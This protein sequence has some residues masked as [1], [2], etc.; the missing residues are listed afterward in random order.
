LQPVEQARRLQRICFSAAAAIVLVAVPMG[1]GSEDSG[2]PPADV[3]GPLVNP[4][5]RLANC[6]D[7]RS[8]SVAERLG[9]VRQLREF[10]GGPVG[11]SELKQGPV[12]DDKQAYELLQR[13]CAQPFARGFK[14]Y[15]LYVRAAGFAGKPPS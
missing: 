5:L 2:Q 11:S 3:G 14:L 9:T 8:S 15:K 13:Y 1:C 12:L 7:W 4:E 10:A 6:A